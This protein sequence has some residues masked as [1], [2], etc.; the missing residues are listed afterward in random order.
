MKTSEISGLTLNTAL[1]TGSTWSP[2]AGTDYSYGNVSVLNDRTYNLQ[3]VNSDARFMA[4]LYGSADKE[5]FYFPIDVGAANINVSFANYCQIH[6][7][8][9][10]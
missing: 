4:L 2:I 3:H 1:I 6:Y 10:I 7:F 8:T 9:A 5:S